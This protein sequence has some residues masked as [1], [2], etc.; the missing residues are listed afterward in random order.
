M[1]TVSFFN[2]KGGV[3]KTT[4]AC[5]LAAQL[6]AKNHRVLMIDCDPQCNATVLV[7]GEDEAASLYWPE[8]DAKRS[9]TN[10]ILDVVRP[11]EDGDAEIDLKVL[12]VP[13]TRNRFG[14]DFLPGH[15]R[16]SVVEDQLS[17]AWRDAMSGEIGGLRK[18]TWMNKLVASLGQEHDYVFLDLGPSLGSLN[19]SALLGS[20]YFCTPMG[21]DIFSILG[22][23]NISEWIRAWS[24]LY[25]N[26][27]ALCGDR[28]P[29]SIERYSIPTQV[30]LTRGYLGY[31]VQSYVAK[32]RGGKRRATK[33]FEAIL[34]EFPTEVMKHLGENLAPGVT[35][36]SVHLGD[37][38]NMFSIVPLAQSAAAPISDLKTSDGVVGAHHAQVKKYGVLLERVADA[39]H[40]N[41][42]GAREDDMA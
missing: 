9:S 37:I 24:S 3:G 27:I 40:K 8:S 42:T 26:A 18:S 39:L 25:V 6:A 11:L 13:A 5:N 31:T 23:R 12:P 41:M 19:R 7:L 10:T 1:R 32:Y 22:L 30:A 38:P 20:E 2:N 16:L 34:Q 35:A 36:D 29:G 33:A 15:P 17:D 14:V 4:L 28:K 21:A